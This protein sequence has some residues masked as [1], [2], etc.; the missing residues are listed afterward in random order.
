L[1]SWEE[2]V[3]DTEKKILEEK[4]SKKYRQDRRAR[5]A[6]RDLLGERQKS[7]QL[8]STTPWRE[9]AQAV[10]N[11]SRYLSLV[12]MSGSTPHDLF[13]DFIEQ[14]GEK[15]KE[16]SKKLKKWAKAKGLVITSTST[17]EWFHDQLKDS[18]GYSEV[19]EEHRWALFDSLMTKAKE[20]DEDAEKNAKKNRKKFVELLQRARDVTA[21]TTYE[22]ATKSLGS[23]PEWKAVDEQIRRQCFEIFVDQLKI[24]SSSKKD[25]DDDDG[26]K[27]GA[28]KA[29]TKKR[30]EESP[31]PESPPRKV[32]K[33]K[34]DEDDDDRKK[35]K[36]NKEVSVC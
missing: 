11:D 4:T 27:A 17:R 12:G 34:R 21:A 1:T 23:N 6:F 9:V 25:D 2:W 19:S 3:G 8:K 32:A 16:D 15:Y 30:K 31:P 29:T 20:Q 28:K 36:K 10:E 22:M 5:D 33:K 18:E 35:A 24:Q 7:G 26:K 13:D 14:L